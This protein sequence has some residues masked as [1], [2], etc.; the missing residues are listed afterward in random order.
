VRLAV[1]DHGIGIVEADRTRI[2]DRFERAVS[3]SHYGGL[4]LGLYISDQIVR[5]H[6]GSIQVESDVG[7]GSKLVVTLPRSQDLPDPREGTSQRAK[8]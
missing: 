6:G 7:K 5:A 3:A 4:G 8:R 2:F 1:K